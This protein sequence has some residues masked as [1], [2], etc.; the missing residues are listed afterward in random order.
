MICGD[1]FSVGYSNSKAKNRDFPCEVNHFA[2]GH[3][4]KHHLKPQ[5]VQNFTEMRAY[6][7]SCRDIKLSSV[8]IIEH[9]DQYLCNTVHIQ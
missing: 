5:L 3:Q 6:F 1:L 9:D 7:A 8:P 2:N 4:R